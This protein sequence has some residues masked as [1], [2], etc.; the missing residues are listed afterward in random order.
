MAAAN[1]RADTTKKIIGTRVGN[2]APRGQAITAIAMAM[3]A[4]SE[5]PMTFVPEPRLAMIDRRQTPALKT[6]S[7]VTTHRSATS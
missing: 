7:S 2:S 1:H 6:K 3:I 4:C 5:L